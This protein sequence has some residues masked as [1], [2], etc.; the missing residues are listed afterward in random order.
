[1]CVSPLT[2]LMMDQREKFAPRGLETEFVGEAQDDEEVVKKVREGKIQLVYISPENL[3]L[4]PV[5]RGMLNSDHYKQ[6]LVGFVID[7]AH[8][9][10]TWWVH[11][12]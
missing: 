11:I 3:L 6:N 4:N 5:Y 1:M 2:A 12:E 10:K 8:C 7:E 9:V